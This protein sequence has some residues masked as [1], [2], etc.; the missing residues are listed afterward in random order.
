MAISTAL[1]GYSA[2]ATQYG[3]A[4]QEIAGAGLPIGEA[5]V[6]SPDLFEAVVSADLAGK[7]MD[8]SVAMLSTALEQQSSIID[9][10]A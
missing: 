8:V 6:V 2:A 1:N 7:Q 3:A 9:I 5:P 4:T 10:L